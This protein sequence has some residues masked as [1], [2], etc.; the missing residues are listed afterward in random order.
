[1]AFTFTSCEDVPNPFGQIVPPNGS[2]DD[3]VEFEPAGSGTLADPYNVQAIINTVS[4]LEAG[5][6]LEKEMY[7]KG[8]VTSIPNNGISSSYNNATFYISDDKEGNN[9]KAVEIIA[10]QVHF[11]ESKRSREDDGEDRAA[12]A[13][14]AAGTLPAPDASGTIPLK[15][16]SSN[17]YDAADDPRLDDDLPF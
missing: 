13:R 7:V 1:M 17:R 11:C 16:Q 3:V 6:G 9:R 12:Q 8:Y 14:A 4:A 15:A 10:D 2:G 5:V